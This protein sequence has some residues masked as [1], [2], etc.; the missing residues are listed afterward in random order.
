MNLITIMIDSLRFDHVG[1]NGNSWIRT[2]NL[3]ALAS[4]S[5]QFRN[6][7]PESLPT[8]P[9]RKA[10]FTGKRI[11][12][13]FNTWELNHYWHPIPGWSPIDHDTPVMAEILGAKGYLTGFI[14]D[15]YHLFRPAMNYHRGFEHWELIRGQEVDRSRSFANHVMDYSLF[16][17]EDMK[18]M[19]DVTFPMEIYMRKVAD[20]LH[21]EEWFPPK[22]FRAAARWI[23]EN[24]KADKFFLWVDSFDPHEPWDPPQ[25]YR[26]LYS[27]GYQGKEII[28]PPYSLDL[29]FLTESELKYM[30]ACYAG[31]VTMVD[32]WLG[33]FLSMVEDLGLME[34][35]IIVLLSD[36]GI[37]LGDHGVTGKPQEA[38]YPELLKLN[39][40]IKV[41]KQE[42]RA[43]DSMVYTHDYLP[44]LFYLLGEEIPEHVEGNNLWDLVEGKRSSF[45]EYI[46]SGLKTRVM[47]YD[48]RYWMFCRRDCSDVSLFDLKE[49][50]GCNH[51]IAKDKQD[52]VDRFFSLVVKD[53]GG[54][55]TIL[56]DKIPR[57]FL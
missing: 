5:V 34:N 19:H 35:T 38:L 24:Y 1:I 47:A 27:L 8:L 42:P 12:P 49:D 48:G 29:D 31:E 55:L 33:Y 40:F 43:I 37:L 36:H 10:L 16:L 23:E 9:V 2:P 17:T 57:N 45:R 22:V 50:P 52:V 3:D 30:Q 15:T 4:K 6:A 20:R 21:E 28:W 44:T 13:Y 53:A 7:F 56:P 54:K 46:T 25:R 51:N 18:K 39:F 41:P 26:D 11:F 32:T 14:T